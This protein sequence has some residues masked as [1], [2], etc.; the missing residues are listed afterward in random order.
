MQSVQMNVSKA[1]AQESVNV[2]TE[3]NLDQEKKLDFKETYE[4]AKS[5]KSDQQQ[6]ELQEQ[7]IKRAWQD[8]AEELKVT[9]QKAD[10]LVRDEQI[11]SEELNSPTKSKHVEE[12]EPHYVDKESG[13]HDILAQIQAAEQQ[14][15]P[16]RQVADNVNDAT[17]STT[18]LSNVESTVS[19]LL[20]THNGPIQAPL[21]AP[22]NPISQVLAELQAIEG[23]SKP[24]DAVTTDTDN[25]LSVLA[26]EK[27]ETE[28]N[29]NPVTDITSEPKTANESKSANKNA[30]ALESS[31]TKVVAVEQINSNK[32]DVSIKEDVKTAAVEEPKQHPSQGKTAQVVSQV[33]PQGQETAI[34]NKVP[35]QEQSESLSKES[36]SNASDV[37]KSFSSIK[38]HSG[39]AHAPFST[40]NVADSEQVSEPSALVTK[41]ENKAQA[42]LSSMSSVVKQEADDTKQSPLANQGDEKKPQ[43]LG[44]DPSPVKSTSPIK[45]ASELM[46]AS[47]LEPDLVQNKKPNSGTAVDNAF[48]SKE[49]SSKETPLGEKMDTRAVLKEQGKEMAAKTELHETHSRETILKEQAQTEIKGLGASSREPIAQQTP[50]TPLT[51][52]QTIPSAQAQPMNSQLGLHNGISSMVNSAGVSQ[53]A[54][55]PVTSFSA[56]EMSQKFELAA[57]EAP[58]V[59]RERI[60]MMMNK[61]IAQAEIKLDP[62]E[63][64]SMHVKLTM[65]NDQLS[66][67]VQTTQ[68]QSKELVEQHMPRLRE[69]LSQQGINLG[70]SQVGHQQSGSGEMSQSQQQGSG[71]GPSDQQFASSDEVELKPMQNYVRSNSAIDYYA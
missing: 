24:K 38:A 4:A 39:P 40:S 47:E 54:G 56:F 50:A 29:T 13:G 23:N 15:R 8:E 18:S 41:Q 67:N 55:A 7:A 64:G 34:V 43:A 9:R 3:S 21:N 31:P 5:K 11:K 53:P 49:L 14:V 69:L 16:L 35:Q 32:E 57:K 10:N 37:A 44:L 2:I 25:D 52:Q 46:G 19:E 58:S 66:I 1:P 30:A 6:Q 42:Q 28:K 59:M 51:A 63:L 20:E 45:V 17:T 48:N 60:T 12:G 61:G 70:E 71:R 62:A 65:Q 36:T 22:L 33:L 68:A 26:S 27:K